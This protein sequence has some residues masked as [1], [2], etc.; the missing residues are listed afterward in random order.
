MLLSM[1]VTMTSCAP[2][3]A[4]ST[5]AMPAHSAPPS[6]GA[7]D[8]EQQV[9]PERQVEREPDEAGEDATEDDLALGADVEQPGAEPDAQAE[10]GEDQRRRDGERL[11]QR[12]DRA[13]ER[14]GPRVVDRPREQGR[15]RLGHRRPRGGDQVAGPREEVA[16]RSPAPRRRPRR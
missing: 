4:L 2:V 5:P 15:V 1:I 8:A 12:P 9:Q 14:L 10:A 13:R 6:A 3:R 7:E 16:P 11:G